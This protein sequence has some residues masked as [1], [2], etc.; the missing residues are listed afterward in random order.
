MRQPSSPKSRAGRNSGLAQAFRW[1]LIFLFML[2]ALAACSQQTPKPEPGVLRATLDNGLKVVIVPNKLAP[3]ATV[4]V[5]YLAGSNEA[6]PGFPG[7]AHAQEHMMFRGSPG[8]SANQLA[9]ITAAMGGRFNANTQQ[10]LTQYYFTVP[11]SDLE[12]A[13]HIGAT[14]MSG[15]LNTEKLWQEER[16]AIEQ[17]IARDLSNPQYVFY[18]KL[19]AAMFKGTPYAHDALGTKPSF[20]QT[21]G[22]MLKK[23]YDTWY[24]P[25]NAILVIAGDVDPHQALDQVKRLFGS[26]PS[27]PLPPRPQVNLQPVTPET[28]QLKTDRSY[29]LAVVSFRLP[30]YDSPDYAATRVLEGV[31]SSQ[32]G[33]LYGLT[34]EGKALYSSFDLDTM[35]QVG[36]GMA[37]AAFPKDAN[38]ETLLQEMKK[39]LQDYLQQGLPPDLVTAAKNLAVAQAEYQKDSV[40]G[41]AMTWSK[42]LTLEGRQDPQAMVEAIKKV[43]LADVNRV[44]RQYLNLDQAIV[45]VLTPEHSGQPT[46]TKGFSRK[47]TL[48]IQPTE[49]VTLPEWA[50]K[51][52]NELAV[53]PSTVHPVVTT[54]PNGIQLFVQ[55][56]SVSNSVIVLG[57]IRNRPDLQTPPGQDGVDQVLEQLFTYGTTSLD[58]L[59]FQKALDDVAA[60]VSAGTSFVLKVLSNHFE[61]GVEL[62]ADNELH[63]AL[64][65]AAF[66]IVRTQVAG[67]VAGELQ[68]PDYLA[69]RA[70]KIAL[71]PPHDPTL[72]QAT[73]A[74]VSG[75][76]LDD[77]K[78]YF[79]S[80][81]RPD[82]AAIVIIGNVTPERAKAAIERYF[83]SWQAVGPK[84]NTLLPP[85]PPNT[86]SV[87]NVPDVSRIQDQVILAETLGLTRDNPDF[88]ALKLGNH[89]LGGGFYATRLYQDLRQKTGLVYNVS[90]ELNSHQTRA[91]YGV[92]Y[93]CNPDNVARARGIVVDNLQRMVQQPVDHD[94]LR[95]AQ[96]MLLKEITLSESSLD[97]IAL[98][99]I[100]RWILDLPWV[101]PTIAAKH[102]IALTPDQVQAAFAKWLR[103]DD[104]VQITQGPPPK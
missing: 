58:R 82:K 81:Y 8:L 13:L 28:M 21:T 93:G 24:V 95:Q 66:K 88:Y 41:L 99:L 7:M 35:P 56:E 102:Y 100:H 89:V 16:G 34:P 48:N 17:E 96:S 59:A 97:S 64:P 92:H 23:Y 25:N 103:P 69:A 6:P 90:V 19:L 55:P 61:R 75:L 32:R 4:V 5:N 49:K 15:V 18:T 22:A 91:T 45:A 74:T 12:V 1:T 31:L 70:V 94:E 47:E 20:D 46:A 39:V 30:G 80:V 43:T 67:A 98:G 37:L 52:L 87:V 65:E 104:L 38:S 50:Q 63:P 44:A 9:N 2:A 62:L 78:Q 33:N 77:V 54:L 76:S 71:F 57:R 40:T 29:G 53:P 3:V 84:P 60:E 72:R 42:A 83:G 79:K 26:I 101:E 73:P 51:R 10:T 68:S 11:A 14:R 86:P 85:V 36:L 27:K